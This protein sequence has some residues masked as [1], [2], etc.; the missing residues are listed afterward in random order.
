MAHFE[1]VRPRDTLYDLDSFGV[2]LPHIP[3]DPKR[4]AAVMDYG[5][6]VTPRASKS[7]NSDLSLIIQNDFELQEAYG[8]PGVGLSHTTSHL[9]LDGHVVLA[10]TARPL[11]GPPEAAIAWTSGRYSFVLV[12][13]HHLSLQKLLRVARSFPVQSGS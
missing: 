12:G 10:G 2:S 5:H 8:S 4:Y 1:I 9:R 3:G 13:F 6:L 7:G 11:S